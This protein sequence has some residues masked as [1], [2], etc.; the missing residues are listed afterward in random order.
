MA[1]NHA[2]D[3]LLRPAVELYTVQMCLAMAFLCVVA[4]WVVALTPLFGLVT[5]AAFLGFGIYRLCQA[6]RMLRYR[7][8]IWRLSF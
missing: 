4:P 5:A 2:L 8:N 7:R 6:L 1:R 3:T